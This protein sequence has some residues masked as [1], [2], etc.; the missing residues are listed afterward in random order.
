MHYLQQDYSPEQIVGYANRI[1]K[2]C[3]LVERIYQFVWK[4]KKNGG[5]LYKHLRTRGKKY[6]KTR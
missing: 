1:G 4:D 5:L 2:A 6:K 3:V